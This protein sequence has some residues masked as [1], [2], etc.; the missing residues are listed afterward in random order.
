MVMHGR[1]KKFVKFVRDFEISDL[2][3]HFQVTN[4]AHR[5]VMRSIRFN[6][7]TLFAEPHAIVDGA[8]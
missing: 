4:I 5:A 6:M 2:I 3:T 7:L 1:R 8:V